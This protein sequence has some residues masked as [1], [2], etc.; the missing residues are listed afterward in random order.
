MG[1]ARDFIDF[2]KDAFTITGAVLTSKWLWLMVGFAVYFILQAYLM[3][4]ISPLVLL[5]M[6]GL[7]IG[8]LFWDEHRRTKPILKKPQVETID[9]DV[10]ANLDN[11]IKALTKTQILDEDRKKDYE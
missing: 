1:A 11:Y 10:K 7:L 9:W 4:A 5:I 3:L 8:Y 2:I 6:P